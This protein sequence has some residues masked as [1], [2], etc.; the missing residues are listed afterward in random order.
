LR[1]ADFSD[2]AAGA[3]ATFELPLAALE[4][5]QAA[6]LIGSNPRHDQPLLGQRLRKAWKKGAKIHA[7]NPLDFDFN[8]LLAGKS[9]VLPH[10]FADELAA[11]AAA[12]GEGGGQTLAPEFAAR[13]SGAKPSDAHR[14]TV[15]ALRDAANSVVVFGDWATHHAEAALL[16]A[17]AKALAAATQSKFNELPAGANAVGLARVGALPQSGGRNAAALLASPPKSFLSYHLGSQDTSSPAAY[18]A[19]RSNADFHVYIGAYACNG[20]KRTAHAVL[21]IGLAPEIDGTYVNVDGSVQTVP[22]GSKLPGASR[23]G[24]KVLRALGAALGIAGFDFVDIASVRAAMG[25]T[26]AKA[27]PVAGSGKFAPAAKPTLAQGQFT[28][29]STVPLYR[30]D[31]VVRRAQSL[32]AHPLTGHCAIGLN[33]EDALALGLAD[34]ARAK[35]S[36]GNGDVELPVVITRAVP[37]GGAWIEKTWSETRSLPGNGGALTVTRA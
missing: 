5:V 26:V 32:Q 7:L 35:V 17:L 36:G 9:I 16:R 3:G 29:I 8:F 4:N 13:V 31:A 10:A 1:V 14:A 18:D 6:L 24:W 11:L 30:T 27:A 28:R 25:E 34:G 33:P 22:A 37:R 12:A 15:K 21:P 20:V 23:P 19:A 2:A